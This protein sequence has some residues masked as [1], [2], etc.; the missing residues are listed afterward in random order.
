MKPDRFT[1][2]SGER[3][4]KLFIVAAKTTGKRAAGYIRLSVMTEDSYSPT[5]QKD[6]ILKWCKK[7][8]WVINSDSAIIDEEECVKIGGGDFYVDLGFSGSKGIKRPAYL[9]LME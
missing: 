1:C 2:L 5:T 8:G 3:T 7:E 9:A 4:A 6:D